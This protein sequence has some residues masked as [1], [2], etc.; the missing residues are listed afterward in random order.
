M[1]GKSV[2][3]AMRVRNPTFSVWYTMLSSHTYGGSTDEMKS[4]V[5]GWVTSTIYSLAPIPSKPGIWYD[6]NSLPETCSPQPECANPTVAPCDLAQRK[7]GRSHVGQ[8][9][10]F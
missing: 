7:I 5:F 4:T 10:I 1:Q 9:S 6:G 2:S 3:P 8:S